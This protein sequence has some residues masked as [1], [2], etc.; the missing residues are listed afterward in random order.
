MEVLN[1]S[2]E[3]YTIDGRKI[4]VKGK[5]F[6]ISFS[7]SSLLFAYLESVAL[8]IPNADKWIKCSKLYCL[9]SF[10]SIDGNKVTIK[11]T[12]DGLVTSDDPNY[13]MGA[14]VTIEK[15]SETSDPADKANNDTKTGS[16][17]NAL[18]AT[19]AGIV[20]MTYALFNWFK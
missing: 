1:E 18:L 20:A 17:S 15:G 10:A 3:L 14:T 4:V 2:D 16:A 19:A 5:F 12:P 11:L 9:Q 6:K 7:P 13:P 8:L